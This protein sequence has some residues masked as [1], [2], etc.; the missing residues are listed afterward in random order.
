[1]LN[2]KRTGLAILLA[3][4]VLMPWATVASPHP[5]QRIGALTTS[6]DRTAMALPNCQG[7]PIVR[8][9]SVTLTCAD[10]N[11]SVNRIRWTGWGESFSAG[12]GIASL[13][14]CNPDCSSGHFHQYPTVL[15]VSGKQHCLL[16]HITFDVNARAI[17]SDL[18]HTHQL[19]YVRVTYAFEG[20]S[21]FPADAPGTVKPVVEFPCHP[22]P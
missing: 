4:A 13:N 8:P 2:L 17:Y 1:M 3:A 10:A 16:G 19:A 14:D 21:P 9:S 11:F 20:A 7:K 15:I 12:V 5:N 6:G 22:T 18:R